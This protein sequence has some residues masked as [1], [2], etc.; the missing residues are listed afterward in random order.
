L[1]QDLRNK[2]LRLTEKSNNVKQEKREMRREEARMTRQIDIIVKTQEVKR[3]KTNQGRKDKREN[4]ELRS[5][6]S[7]R[8]FLPYHAR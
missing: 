3:D 8:V 4:K 1:D 7:K 6:N 5:K 2:E